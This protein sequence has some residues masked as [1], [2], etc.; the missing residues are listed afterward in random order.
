MAEKV[1]KV[2]F[3]QLTLLD[4]QTVVATAKEGANIDGAKV[5]IAIDLIESEL[6]GDYS[7]ILERKY[8]YSV[9]PVEVYKFF[10]SLKKL[11]AIAIIANSDRTFLPDNME[12]RIFGRDLEMFPTIEKAYEWINS[13]LSKEDMYQYDKK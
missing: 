7:L 6:P 13:L 10:A 2:D 11:K 4:D 1:I 8:D 5:K 3:G 12:Q 9:M